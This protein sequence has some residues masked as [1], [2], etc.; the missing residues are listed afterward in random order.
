MMRDTLEQARLV[1]SSREDIRVKLSSFPVRACFMRNL[2][3][4]NLCGLL[5]LALGNEN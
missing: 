1:T 2:I 4:V 3:N 5:F